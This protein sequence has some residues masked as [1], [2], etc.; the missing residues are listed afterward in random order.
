MRHFRFGVSVGGAGSR[1]EWGEKVRRVE[2]LGYGTLLVA[3]HLGTSLGALPALVAAAEATRTLRVGTFVLNN[4]F[5]RPALLA[6][7]LATVDLLTDGRLEVGLGAGH[8]ASEY[9]EAGLPFDP[10]GVRVARLAETVAILKRLFA[11]ETV[12]FSGHH[13]AVREHGLYPQPAQRPRAPL[14][15]GGHSRAL[16][17]LAAREADIVGLTGIRHRPGAPAAEV[18]GFRPAEIDERMDRMKNE[19]GERFD[20]LELNALVQQV[21]V[22]ENPRERAEQ[23]AGRVGVLSADDVLGSPFLLLGTVDAM[24][25]ALQ[26]HRAR[27]G[28]SYYVVFEPAIEALAPVV[29]RLTGS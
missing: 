18:T 14:L 15:I 12:T 3:D 16:L 11:G 9:A 4:D 1:A 21:I 23:I 24:V 6:R 5:Y 26:A 27:W 22:T 17:S 7:D 8:M 10:I 20:A 25:E 13:H 29:A 28:I 19:A 2:G